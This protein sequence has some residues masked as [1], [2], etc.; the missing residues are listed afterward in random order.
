M[1]KQPKISVITIV[2][3]DVKHIEETMHSVLNQTYQNIEY[4]VIDG[5]ST[6]GTWDIICKYKER[7]AFCS[8]EPDKGIYDAMN[9]GIKAITGEWCLFMNCGDTFFEKETIDKVFKD[10]KD[11]GESL[12][13]GDTNLVD[14]KSHRVVKARGQ[15]G[16][17]ECMPS[18]HQSIFIRSKEMK[19]HPYDLRYKIAADYAFFYE[20]YERN[21]NYLYSSL[22]ISNY[23]ANGL[24]RKHEDVVVENKLKL[25]M[26][27][28]DCRMFMYFLMWLKRKL[29][30]SK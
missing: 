1:K 16:K 22:I 18:F 9:K 5:A 10:Y 7:L 4:I 14:G 21:S 30:H 17:N 23:E 25:Y 11:C 26:R 13:Y 20:L 6:D 24:S 15:K 8:S 3:N 19:E 28:K 12:I 2:W 29:V 27:H